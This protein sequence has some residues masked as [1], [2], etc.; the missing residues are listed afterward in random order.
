MRESINE[1][2]L[3]FIIN[4]MLINVAATS[5]ETGRL[6]FFI[7]LNSLTPFV[8][9]VNKRNVAKFIRIEKIKPLNK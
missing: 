6:L 2:M 9:A 4:V 7:S 8:S 5:K 1:E 3:S